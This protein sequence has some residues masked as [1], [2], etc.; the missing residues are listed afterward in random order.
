MACAK[1]AWIVQP[2]AP[3]VLEVVEVR[4]EQA[5]HHLH[6]LAAVR[7]GRAHCARHSTHLLERGAACHRCLS[8]GQGKGQ[9]CRHTDSA[10]ELVCC[11]RTATAVILHLRLASKPQR[12]PLTDASRSGNLTA[13]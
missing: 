3:H 8:A 11:S 12:K 5:W 6:Q 2:R 1:C 9:L 13:Y 10:N 7:A 4:C